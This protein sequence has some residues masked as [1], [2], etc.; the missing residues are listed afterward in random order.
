MCFVLAP[1]PSS[2]CRSCS[3]ARSDFLSDADAN[4]F[5]DMAAFFT[6]GLITLGISIPF[7]FAHTQV[8][9]STAAIMAFSGGALVYTAILSFQRSVM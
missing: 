7:I 8:I 3:N 5:T 6:A 9:T 2:L 1:V 4:G